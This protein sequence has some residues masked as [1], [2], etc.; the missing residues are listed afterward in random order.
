MRENPKLEHL[1]FPEIIKIE[2]TQIINALA[3][4]TNGLSSLILKQNRGKEITHNDII[5]MKKEFKTKID[6]Y[7]KNLNYNLRQIPTIAY[8][9][10]LNWSINNF[11]EIH[12]NIV[13]LF[14][15]EKDEK[16]SNDTTP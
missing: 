16:P 13:K 12:K 1:S 14:R 4:S 11:K 7:S 5:R 2:D 6:N 3:D 10:P 8:I 9:L 15:Q